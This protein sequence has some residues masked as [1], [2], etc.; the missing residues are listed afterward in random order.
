MVGQQISSFGS[1]TS[2][3]TADVA[4]AETG[5][6]SQP[7]IDGD[8]I[9]WIEGRPLEKGRN[10]V[11]AR[12]ADGTTRDVTTAPFSVRSQVYSYGGGA[13][14]VS[15]NVV[16]FVNFGDNQIY[17]Q[18]ASGVPTK[19][20]SSAN[21][22]FADIC[23]DAARNRL[24]AIK[25]ER[26]NGDVIKAIHTL[27]AIDI[28]TGREATLDSGCD[29]YSSPTLNVDGSK[30]AWL[31]WQHPNMPWTST[32]LNVAGLDQAGTLTDK[33]IVQGGSESI[34]QPQWSPDGRLYFISDR[35]DFWNLYRWNASG[36]EHILARDAEFGVPQWLLGLSTYAF[37]S[38]E[39]LIY[40]FVKNGSW[41]L[42]RLELP[43]LIAHD[44]PME[45]SS[46]SGV[47]ATAT[48]IVIRYATVTSPQETTR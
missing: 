6:L 21:C 15:N 34:F 27:V 22:L 33:Q 11:V 31:S 24:I 28:A 25:E 17:Q 20:T 29:F 45:F 5:S 18:G 32:Y 23:I 30:L 1:W 3:I 37:M 38:P 10:I 13:Y 36:V 48:T 46:L 9:Y 12:A 42:G 16:Y 19:I 47:Q 39:I 35:T 26:P 2:P 8:N 40:S 44:Y 14:A 43:R 4:V 7:R 41:R